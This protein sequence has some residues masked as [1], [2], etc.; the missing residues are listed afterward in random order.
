MS[1]QVPWIPWTSP[2]TLLWTSICTPTPFSKNY[3]WNTLHR[4]WMWSSLGHTYMKALSIK[5][6]LLASLHHLETLPYVVILNVRFTNQQKCRTNN[7]T[8]V[9]AIHHALKCMNIL[10][11]QIPKLMMPKLKYIILFRWLYQIGF[12]CSVHLDKVYFV[13]IA[14]T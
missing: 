8:K 12:I 5:V 13:Q 3:H 1:I 9:Y 6:Q 14:F 4:L 2:N 7:F 10:H 11:I